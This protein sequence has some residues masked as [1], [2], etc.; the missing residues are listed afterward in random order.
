M[1]V[2]ASDKYR[3]EKDEICYGYLLF[4]NGDGAGGAPRYESSLNASSQ[5]YICTSGPFFLLVS[6]CTYPPYR[7]N[8]VLA[9]LINCIVYCRPQGDQGM[10]STEGTIEY[11]FGWPAFGRGDLISYSTPLHFA[12][13][14]RTVLPID[15][16]LNVDIVDAGEV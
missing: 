13:C 12:L 8:P 6:L 10:I 7:L 11:R 16:G 1:R 2:G 14:S 9:R 4:R 15:P 3:I 5:T